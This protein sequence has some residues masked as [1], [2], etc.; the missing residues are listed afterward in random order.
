MPDAPPV[1][2]RFAQDERSL[3]LIGDELR[4][5]DSSHSVKLSKEICAQAVAAWNRNE[6]GTLADPETERQREVRNNSGVLAL[7]GLAI[8]DEGYA[9]GDHIAVALPPDLVQLAIAAADRAS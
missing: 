4:S 9:V 1:Y 5:Q 7:I 6:S 8:S 3:Q 2:V